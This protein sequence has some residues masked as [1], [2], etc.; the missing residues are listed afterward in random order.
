MRRK[1]A[2]MIGSRDMLAVWLRGDGVAE[3]T[4]DSKFL[5]LY[6][7]DDLKKG[8]DKAGELTV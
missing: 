7:S 4:E 1:A 6:T 8:V 5:C 2:G 3:K